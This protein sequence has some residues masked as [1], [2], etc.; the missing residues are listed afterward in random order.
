MSRYSVEAKDPEKFT[1]IIGWDRPLQTYF[2]QV[3]RK[4]SDRDWD[5]HLWSGCNP[6]ELNTVAELQDAVRK[7]AEIPQETQSALQRDEEM[8]R[9]ASHP[10]IVEARGGGIE[11]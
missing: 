8:G 2:A 10:Y 7:Y 4:D 3:I 11:R 5:M 1:V 9:D 6:R